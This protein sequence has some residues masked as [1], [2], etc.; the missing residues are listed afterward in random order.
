MT[1]YWRIH[2]NPKEIEGL[3][4]HEKVQKCL[5][6]EKIFIGFPLSLKG[7]K[8]RINLGD[9][10]ISHDGCIFY[11]G[12]IASDWKCSSIRGKKIHYRCVKWGKKG[13]LKGEVKSL[14]HWSGHTCA[15][16]KNQKAINFLNKN[17]KK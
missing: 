14:I 10:V 2:A 6:E 9:I 7:F 8:E 13:E 11:V 15:E 12:R 17:K 5:R 1:R 3:N 4:R 16:I